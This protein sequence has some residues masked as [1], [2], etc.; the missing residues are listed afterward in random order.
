MNFIISV[1][2]GEF[3]FFSGGKNANNSDKTELVS[4]Y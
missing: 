2:C 3:Y 4:W 1:I